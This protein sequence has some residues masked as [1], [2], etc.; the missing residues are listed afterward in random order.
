MTAT[1]PPPPPSPQRWLGPGVLTLLGLQLALLWVQGVQLNR[2][3]QD[4]VNL[5]T[6]VQELAE[7]LDQGAQPDYG[8]EANPY[9]PGRH[10]GR[11]PRWQ[12]V[13]QEPKSE[14]KP[15]DDLDPAT[16]AAQKDLKEARE[17]ARKGVEDARKAQ[18][19]LSLSENAR[20]AEEKAKV[21]EARAAWEVWV[22]VAGLVVL[23]AFLVRGWLR[24]RET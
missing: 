22:L 13:R 12:R 6:D 4:L 15:A 2:Q 1:P 20:K 7:S 8:E 21:Q 19:Q 10:H 11:A 17:S 9:V 18:S 5:R 16:Q 24:A 23:G 14:S 3:H